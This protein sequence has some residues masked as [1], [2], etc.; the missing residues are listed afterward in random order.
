MARLMGDEPNDLRRILHRVSEG[1]L[2]RLP[3]LEAL[4]ERLSRNVEQL[5]GAIIYATLVV[6]GALC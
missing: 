2:G 6:C 1:D 3:A 5:A 4:G